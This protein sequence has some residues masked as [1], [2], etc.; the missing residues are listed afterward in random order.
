MPKPLKPF[1]GVVWVVVGGF[2]EGLE[3]FGV[4]WDPVGFNLE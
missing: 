2:W 3:S 4:F 1:R